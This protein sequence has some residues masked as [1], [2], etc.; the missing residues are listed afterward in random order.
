[1]PGAA[2][3]QVSRG[4]NIQH[5]TAVRLRVVG[6]G[7]LDMEFFA[8][9]NTPTYPLVP[10]VLAASTNIQP[11]RLSNVIEQRVVFRLGTDAIDEWFRVNRIIL[12]TKEFATSYPG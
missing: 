4:E 12:F 5:L 8:Q 6:S 1:M 7:N 3:S 2:S 9:D 10:F 11:T